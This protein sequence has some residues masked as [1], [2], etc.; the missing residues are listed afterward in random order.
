MGVP[1]LDALAAALRAAPALRMIIVVPRYPDREDLG[2]G[3]A[4]AISNL[5]RAGGSRV[6]VY[7]LENEHGTPIYVQGHRDRRRLGD[8]GLGQP[9]PALLDP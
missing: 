8:G 4:W 7:D 2:P 9:Q 1:G 6:A 5:V 3:R